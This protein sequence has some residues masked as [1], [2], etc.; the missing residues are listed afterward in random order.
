MHLYHYVEYLISNIFLQIRGAAIYYWSIP[1]PYWNNHLKAVKA[2]GFNTIYT[3]VEWRIHEP[4]PGKFNFI[5]EKDVFSFIKLIHK[6][7]Y[8]KNGNIFST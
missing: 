3:N 7:G 4:S 2:A 8:V 5:N 1:K 6:H